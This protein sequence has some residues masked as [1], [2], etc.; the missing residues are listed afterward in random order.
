MARDHWPQGQPVIFTSSYCA[1]EVELQKKSVSASEQNPAAR[2]AWHVRVQQIEASRLV[3]VDESGSNTALTPLYARA[4]KGARARAWVPRNRGCNT[5]IIG[6]LNHQGWQVGVTLEGAADTSVFEVFVQHYL[7]PT[8]QPGQIVVWDNLSIHK[9]CRVQQWIEEAG[10]ELWF[11]PTY[12]PDLNPI[13]LCWSKLKAGLRRAQARTREHLEAAI[14]AG[15]DT[16]S[17]HDAHAWF[18]HCGYQLI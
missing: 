15:L 16:I 9:S 6:A 10:C 3:F 18:T 2:E 13:E 17:T 8:L 7:V 11:L 14:A 4:P 5:T 12:S 1:P